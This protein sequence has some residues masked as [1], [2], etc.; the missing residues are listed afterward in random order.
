MAGGPFMRLKAT[1]C[2]S[3]V[4]LQLRIKFLEYYEIIMLIMYCCTEGKPGS[5][6]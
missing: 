4:N 2:N 6:S 3:Q 1:L 5:E